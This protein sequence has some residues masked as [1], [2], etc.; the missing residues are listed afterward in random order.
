LLH[1]SNLNKVCN[2]IKPHSIVNNN[3]IPV[4]LVSTLVVS[5]C[6]LA[7]SREAYIES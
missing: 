6:Q 3:V 2:N 7:H 4:L 1:H 5:L